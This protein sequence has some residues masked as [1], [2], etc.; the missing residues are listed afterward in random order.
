M[1]VAGDDSLA[2]FADDD[3]SCS[4]ADISPELVCDE[5]TEEIFKLVPAK[6]IIDGFTDKCKVSSIISLPLFQLRVF[7]NHV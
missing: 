5:Q 6:D 1:D 2:A 4:I 7:V 3:V